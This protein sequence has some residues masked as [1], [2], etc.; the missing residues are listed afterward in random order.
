MS[1]ILQKN[2]F[3]DVICQYTTKG[4]IIPLRIRIHDEDG[5]YQTFVI[6]AYNHS[7]L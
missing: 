1:A 2:A 4:E 5:V 3:V 7:L 6:K